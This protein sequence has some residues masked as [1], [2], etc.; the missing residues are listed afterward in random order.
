MTTVNE[1]YLKMFQRRENMKDRLDIST[2]TAESYRLL[3]LRGAECPTNKEN[4]NFR[5]R[6]TETAGLHPALHPYGRWEY[7]KSINMCDLFLVV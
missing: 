1:A 3:S 5:K 6:R 4:F 2:S 7:T